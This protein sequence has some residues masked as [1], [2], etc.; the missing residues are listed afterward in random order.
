MMNTC[1]IMHNM[2]IENE[3]GPNLE[4]DLYDLMGQ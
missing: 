2:I 4:Y 3:R 1:M